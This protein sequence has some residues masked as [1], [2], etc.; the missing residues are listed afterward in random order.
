MIN[1]L[2]T[3]ERNYIE[4]ITSGTSQGAH[5]CKNVPIQYKLQLV[6][7]VALFLLFHSSFFFST[8]YKI[9][10]QEHE[11]DCETVDD[12]S[13]VITKISY[14]KV[15]LKKKEHNAPMSSLLFNLKIQR[16]F[17]FNYSFSEICFSFFRFCTVCP[18]KGKIYIRNNAR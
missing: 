6:K 14:F 16:Y 10:H 3:C 5:S 9:D 12:L 1:S 18:T 15:N 2:Q 4:H 11:T 13:R 7:L 8:D 17:N